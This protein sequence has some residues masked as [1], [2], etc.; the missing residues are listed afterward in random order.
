MQQ[1][2]CE[3]DSST[4]LNPKMIANDEE[5]TINILQKMDI[6]ECSDES[7]FSTMTDLSIESNEEIKN[8]VEFDSSQ[9]PRAGGHSI[10][11]NF[12]DSD[13]EMD[14]CKIFIVL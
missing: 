9:Q 7:D 6:E 5:N 12:Y 14:V 1:T 4:E 11:K 13:F 3:S 8:A 2:E 10:A